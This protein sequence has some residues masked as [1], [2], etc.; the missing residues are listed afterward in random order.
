M[1]DKLQNQGVKKKKN[2]KKLR[3]QNLST[4]NSRKWQALHKRREH[5]YSHSW[6]SGRRTRNFPL[7]GLRRN[8]PNLQLSFNG[9]M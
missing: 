3:M 7:T 5:S 8:Q 6:Q 9:Y 1:M 4:L 2:I